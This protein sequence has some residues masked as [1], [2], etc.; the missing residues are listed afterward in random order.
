M[1]KIFVYD[2]E[3]TGTKFWKN[4]VHQISG[5]I[6]IDGKIVER[7]DF[8]VKPNDK[9]IIEDDA[10]KVAR[11]TREIIMA[12]PPMKKVYG[13][14]VK[15]LAKYV[16][17]YDKTD[18]FFLMGYNNAAFDDP[19]FRAWFVQ[20]DDSFFGSWFWADALDVRVLAANHLQDVRSQMENFKLATVAKQLGIEVLEEKLH[21]AE[22]DTELV[23]GIYNQISNNKNK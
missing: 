22:Y 1:S 23:L 7:F 11:V 13:Q 19:F 14:I 6:V 3:T 5:A 2:L 4:G 17:R 8:K 10:L 9:A 18:K 16:S 21:D 20:N 15:M 12:Y